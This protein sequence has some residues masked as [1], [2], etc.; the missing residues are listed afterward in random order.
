MQKHIIHINRISQQHIEEQAEKH[1]V[2]FIPLIQKIAGMTR[3]Q[4]IA[5]SFHN[6]LCSIAS[7]QMVLQEEGHTHINAIEL[8]TQTLQG[9]PSLAMGRQVAIWQ[10]EL[11]IGELI[12]PSY[13]G[14]SMGF[15]TNRNH[16]IQ[17][18]PDNTSVNEELTQR[19][20]D[21]LHFVERMI[22]HGY[23]LITSLPKSLDCTQP[24]SHQV[25]L[26]GIATNTQDQSCFII[27]DPDDT[28]DYSHHPD[29]IEQHDT[30]LYVTQHYWF[31]ELTYGMYL[32]W[33]TKEH[34]HE[35]E[36]FIQYALTVSQLREKYPT[37]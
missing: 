1:K 19:Q 9:H 7:S 18:F 13:I 2:S 30:T 24:R 29:D 15:V 37:L 28:A 8:L 11:H 21:E 22:F 6:V 16:F 33:L 14:Y 10:N 26:H 25:V 34:L 17:K 32:F 3:E 31:S 4:A 23:P 27:T 35:I 36:P 5:L 20:M 12:C